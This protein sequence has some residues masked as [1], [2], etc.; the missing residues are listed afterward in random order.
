MTA[1]WMIRCT[2]LMTGA[3]PSS[4]VLVVADFPPAPPSSA[5]SMAVSV[6]SW[7]IES[8]DSVSVLGA[9]IILV[10]GLDDRFLG[11]QRDFDLAVEHE[12]QLVDRLEVHGDHA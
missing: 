4:R 7:S 11:R 6:N 10:D 1:S 3:S 9:A 8:T 2:S 12:P 5:K